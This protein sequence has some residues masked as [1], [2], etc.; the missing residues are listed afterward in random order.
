MTPQSLTDQ[1]ETRITEMVFCDDQEV[2]MKW[3]KSMVAEAEVDNEGT[4]Y[5]TNNLG[6]RG[7]FMFNS[8]PTTKAAMIGFAIAGQYWTKAFP[9]LLDKIS[10]TWKKQKR[11]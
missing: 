3:L 7:G 8:D 1:C 11:K 5:F 10:V 2:F 4:V 9:T 6:N